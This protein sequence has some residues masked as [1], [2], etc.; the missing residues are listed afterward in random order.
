MSDAP[1][2]PP[3]PPGDRPPP[4]A[5]TR[6]GSTLVA[7]GDEEARR[8]IGLALT[9][10]AG[11]KG[12]ADER[13]DAAR[14][15][16]IDPASYEITGEVGQGGIGRVLR[17]S[18]TRLHRPVALKELLDSAGAAAEERFVREA[19]LTA[20]LQHPSIVPLYEAGRWP[21]GAPF[22]AM[23]LVSGRSLQDILAESRTLDVRLGLLP[24]VLAVAEAMAYAHSERII[25]RDLK[26]GNV[27]VGSFGETVVIDWGLAKDLSRPE[28]DSAPPAAAHPPSAAEVPSLPPPA[29]D[30]RTP[31][32]RSPRPPS[33]R[34]PPGEA[35]TIHGAVIGTPAYMPPEQARGEG[36]DERAD[37][38]ALGAILYHVL[39]GTCPYDGRSGASVLRKVL[40]GPPPPASERQPGIAEDLLAIVN[41][42]MAREP[43]ARYPS[44]RE[45]AEDLRRFQ[46]G[47]IVGAH[48]YSRGELVLRFARR[49]RAALSVAGAA[50]LILAIS[51]TLAVRR[52]MAESHL[53]RE[54]QA[55]AEEAQ[56][57]A[58]S[59]ADDLTLVQAKSAAAHD[60]NRALAWL[61]TLSPGF[62]RWPEARL[63]AADA[64][65][66][67]LSVPLT[68]HTGAVNEARFARDGA[69]LATISDDH[70]VRI[71]D[72]A[73]AAAG[74]P[75][76]APRAISSRLFQGHTDEV[77]A[78][79]VS[80]DGAVLVTG[81][82]DTTLR[83]WDLNTGSSKIVPSG[84]TK[85]VAEI[86]FAGPDLLVTASDD[87]TAR[88]RDAR[89]FEARGV[90]GAPGLLR[91]V[92]VS[93][94]GRTVAGGGYDKQLHIWDV[95]TRGERAL[96]GHGAQVAGV[97]IS[98][99][100][101]VIATRDREGM[102]RLWDA[103]TGASRV[104]SPKVAKGTFTLAPFGKIRFSPDGATLAVAGDGP[105]LRLWDVAGGP[106]RRLEGPQGKTTWTAFSPDGS[107]VAAASQD[108]M[109]HV[110]PL[111]GG[112]HRALPG[113]ETEL[114]TVAFSP[115]GKLLVAAA[116]EG[117]V[118]LFPVAVTASR[119]FEGA[120]GALDAVDVS[121]GGDRVLAAGEDGTVRVWSLATG[122]LTPLDGHEGPV[123][124]ARFS[125]DGQ[126]VAS[127]GLDGTT[128]LWDL[129]GREIWSAGGR[130][131]Q[132]LSV[133]FSP[134]GRL[135]VS[136]G[137]AG[138]V[139]TIDV[140]SGAARELRGEGDAVLSAEISPD[141]ARVSAASFAGT[142]RVWDLATGEGRR[143]A[144]HEH[145]V[146]TAVFSPDG[147]TVASGSL[148][149]TLRLWDLA[150]GQGR[151]IDAGGGGITQAVFSADG[152]TLFT[153]DNYE[154]K[155]RIWD[156]AAGV[157]RASLSGHTGFVTRI[158]VSPDERRLASASLDGTVRLWDLGSGA[159]RILRGH[160]GAVTDVAF[161]PDGK[162]VV[163]GG[164]DGALRVWADDLPEDPAAL[165][166]WIDLTAGSR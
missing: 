155:V 33:G 129:E 106:E 132:A 44:A 126:L 110:W 153:C 164:V 128:R 151:R 26:P 49:Y 162:L 65:S 66:R 15:P 31:S 103:A 25:H 92:A 147:N 76:P 107:L 55:R 95:A 148:D 17:A 127:G 141:G 81:G 104:L 58:A 7:A 19:L 29:P 121:P 68:G 102:V 23:K 159:S 134:D 46:T 116:A 12:A 158:A 75:A 28:P 18:D 24:H 111:A 9:V 69:W 54:R 57:S 4:A 118:R 1:H 157:V 3:P 113:F 101:K 93:R 154:T 115:D 123:S 90:L 72:L 20:R 52:I 119:T 139:W 2:A 67:G 47:Q 131:P 45:L 138:S 51:G 82:K 32:N 94:D 13:P 163:S 98:P 5:G 156:V 96:A 42:A 135:V 99:D 136:P 124:A 85:G 78:A 40:A 36:V 142:V 43:A 34:T 37:V 122:E 97:A 144:G 84:H 80:P 89:T 63:V 62:T 71:W 16:L 59:R 109:A 86:A 117:T 120:R 161:S 61:A 108:H 105:F 41:K 6:D 150:T 77:W 133:V 74:G 10:A 56:R 100:G 22:Y 83:I 48:R 114:T 35:L 130:N 149:H 60:P 145:L 152:A 166:G 125:P 21:T 73:G 64:R 91:T 11:D 39:T 87:G 30:S 88:L 146:R 27:L 53:A 165:R 14:L 79:A 38:Y 70:S 50:L 8:R 140:D 160:A 112:G 137:L 143:F